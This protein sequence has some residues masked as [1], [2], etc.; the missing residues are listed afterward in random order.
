MVEKLTAMPKP[1]ISRFIRSA[2]ADRLAD[3][4]ELGEQAAAVLLQTVI[5]YLDPVDV[6]GQQMQ[7]AHARL[8][9]FDMKKLGFMKKHD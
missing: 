9:T 1:N 2:V 7:R 3:S 6:S 8:T 4:A 5:A